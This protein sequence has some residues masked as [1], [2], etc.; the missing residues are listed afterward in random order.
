MAKKITVTTAGGGMATAT[1]TNVEALR[2]ATMASL[3][4]ENVAYESGVSISER[5]SNLVKVT[6]DADVAQIAID[7]RNKMYLRH[8][9][10]FLV[11]EMTAKKPASTKL[12]ADTLA[13]VVQR[14]DEITEFLSLYWKGGRKMLSKG[15][16]LGLGRAFN[17]FNEYSFAKNAHPDAKVK[18]RD[19]LFMSHAKPETAEMEVLFK[20]IVDN[21]L[22]T[23][24]TWETNLSAGA[25]KK[26][27]FERLL[28][29]H[30]LGGLAT[31]R[32]LRNMID[33]GVDPDLIRDRLE[34]GKFE[35]VLPY[36]FLTAVDYA[37]QYESSIEKAMLN[38]VKSIPKL[39]G[40]TLMILDTSGSMGYVSSKF[41]FSSRIDM[42]IATM[43]VGSALCENTLV[44]LT[45]GSDA[46]RIHATAPVP[47]RQGF[48]LR[49]AIIKVKGK[50]GSGGIFLVQCLS[51]I[52]TL[53]KGQQF[54]RVLVFT[55]E[56]DCDNGVNPRTAKK[57]GKHNY[58]MN[59][60]SE[61]RG[62]GYQ[63]GWTTITGFSENVFEYIR[64]NEG[65]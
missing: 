22:A 55:D 35:K 23:P 1:P 46:Q 29:E 47:S 20:K 32:N 13:E 54:D 44:Y 18:L 58:I 49:D 41:S 63:S 15:V 31:L 24:D 30:K 48:S 12:I 16:R 5:L 61:E 57:L 40:K 52:D 8:V 6:P 65:L 56:Q 3:L 43:I 33:A 17:K 26:A 36:R 50:L 64:Q 53:E 59:V 45:A 62:I 7:A 11:N 60:S 42:G 2:R 34:N 37:P 9:P 21:T 38:C 51:H 19:A 10:L 14:P 39:P 4:W 28:K 27:T 25:D